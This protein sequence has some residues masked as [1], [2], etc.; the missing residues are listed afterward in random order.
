M[1]TSSGLGGDVFTR[2]Y[3]FRPLTL[4]F[5]VKVTLNVDQYSQHHAAYSPERLEVSTSDSS[6][7]DAFT[8]KY[9]I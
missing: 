8:R 3:I 5:V 7:G 9:I 2:K 1:A 6:G 4:T